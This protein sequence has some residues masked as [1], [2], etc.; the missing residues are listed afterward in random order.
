MANRAIR[1]GRVYVEPLLGSTS[2]WSKSR[3]VFDALPAQLGKHQS[4]Q[5]PI[6]GP[7]LWRHEAKDALDGVRLLRSLFLFEGRRERFLVVETVELAPSPGH[8]DLLA[9]PA[10]FE[11]ATVG[12]E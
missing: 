5:S 3:F 6:S 11:P 1:M 2:F 12:L 8:A 7:G 10:G 9:P 4:G